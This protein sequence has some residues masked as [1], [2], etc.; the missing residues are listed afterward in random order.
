[1]VKN[2]ICL[3]SESKQDAFLK[4]CALKIVPK[5]PVSRKGS[6]RNEPLNLSDFTVNLMEDFHK[7]QFS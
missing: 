7:L 5:P 3:E 6:D 1:M 2:D 4:K